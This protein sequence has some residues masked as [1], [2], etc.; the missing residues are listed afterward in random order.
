MRLAGQA[1]DVALTK[2]QVEKSPDIDTH[3]PVSRQHEA[4]YL[5]ITGI[6]VIGWSL[7]VGPSVLPGGH[8]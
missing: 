4:A 3:R 1:L 6:P 5:G 2:K 8:G 7:P